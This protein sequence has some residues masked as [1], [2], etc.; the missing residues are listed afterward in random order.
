ML[1]EDFLKITHELNKINRNMFTQDE[2]AIG[3]YDFKVAYD[4]SIIN[5]KPNHV[6]IN[7]CTELV[8]DMDK[9]DYEDIESTLDIKTMNDILETYL[10]E[11][12]GY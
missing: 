7:L 4:D 12:V 3:A 5:H 9:G 11:Y 6:M 1:Y 8:T 10:L 2:V